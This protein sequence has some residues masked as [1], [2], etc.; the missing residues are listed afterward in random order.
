MY[1]TRPE[2]PLLFKK[3]PPSVGRRAGQARDRAAAL[4]GQIK[5]IGDDWSGKW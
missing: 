2:Q 1:V 4:G 5:N 3:S